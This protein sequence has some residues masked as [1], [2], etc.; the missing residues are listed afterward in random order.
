MGRRT[1]IT[2]DQTRRKLIDA[3]LR[4]AEAARREIRCP[5]A[6]LRQRP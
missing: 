6:V 3:V 5:I 1:G 2:A 4:D